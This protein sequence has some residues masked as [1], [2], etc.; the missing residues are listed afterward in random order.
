MIRY[1]AGGY[2][3]LLI[4][5]LGLF[6]C[7]KNAVN[8]REK[9]ALAFVEPAIGDTINLS[10][11]DELHIEFTATD[12]TGLHSLDV[13]LKDQLGTTYLQNNPNVGNLK[14]YPFHTHLTPSLSTPTQMTL[15][16]LAEDHSGNTEEST[17]QFWV[18]P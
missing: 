8:D 16:V 14:V 10:L 9:P 5:L 3:F 18:M 12:N 15:H 1:T 7:Q 2:A 11:G 6:A 4:S 17:I 13:S